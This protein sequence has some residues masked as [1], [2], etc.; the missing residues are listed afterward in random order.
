MSQL[1][2]TS[3]P[4]AITAIMLGLLP[5]VLLFS[6]LNTALPFIRHALHFSIG[7]VQWMVTLYG[8]FNAS[9]L[10]IAGRLSD[11]HG[12]K[13]FY[14]MGMILFCV[15]LLIAGFSESAGQILFAQVLLGTSCGL[16]LPVSQAL[17]TNLYPENERSTAIGIWASL[18]GVA[19][20]SGPLAAG[21]LLQINWRWIYFATCIATV[22][23]FLLTLLFVPASHNKKQENVSI[24]YLGAFLIIMTIGSFVAAVMETD[25]LAPAILVFLYILSLVCLCLLIVVERRIKHPII[26]ESLFRNRTFMIASLG[27]CV[28]IFFCWSLLFMFPLY[29]HI[30]L[31][32]SAL[33]IGLVMLALTLPLTV[34]SPFVGKWCDVLGPKRLILFGFSLFV[35]S[36]LIEM[37]FTA[38][39]SVGWII[40]AALIYSTGWGLSWSPTTTVAIST[41]PAKEAGIAAGTFLTCQEVGGTVGVAI[42]GTVMRGNPN[43]MH[44][45]IEGIG[46]LLVVAVFGIIVT[47]FLKA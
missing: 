19:L 1:Q 8:I 21:L 41:L 20:G 11:I 36:T 3:R 17:M 44:G 37:F 4:L 46:V 9:A 47:S 33:R 18:V 40:A 13:K 29:F 27:N 34:L 7:T 32:Y 16:L 43:L 10:V 28:V 24:G 5:L 42:T 30:I 25:A 23:G 31:K 6:A 45:F 35:I 15:G 39:T 22:F 26:R 12:H 2:S 38:N 14:I